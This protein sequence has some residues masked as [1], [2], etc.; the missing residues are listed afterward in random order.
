M[1]DS[2]PLDLDLAG[3]LHSWCRQLLGGD[4]KSAHTMKSYRAAVQSFLAF[5]AEDG[6]RAELTKT[7]VTDWMHAQSS[8]TASTVRL[9]LTAI[10]LFARWLAEEEGF[11]ADP[12]VAVKPPKM[13]QPSVP[14]LSENEV[15]RM[16]KV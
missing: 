4:R 16:L 10:K 3:L 12:I 14:D 7:N 1:P 5:C 13:N 11:D 8:N 6:R 9:R 15:R 2:L